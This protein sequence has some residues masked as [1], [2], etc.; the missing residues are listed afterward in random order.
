MVDIYRVPLTP[1][2]PNVILA[3]D[4]CTDPSV[5]GR[6]GLSKCTCLCGWVIALQVERGGGVWWK[7]ISGRDERARPHMLVDNQTLIEVVGAMQGFISLRNNRF[8]LLGFR[9]YFFIG[10]SKF[11]TYR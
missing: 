10:T 2:D 5:K 9:R 6:P 4:P 7:V 8:S 11:L 1:W 3:G